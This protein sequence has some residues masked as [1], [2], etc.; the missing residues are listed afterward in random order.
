M[1]VLENHASWTLSDFFHFFEPPK[2]EPLTLDPRL[3]EAL[4][5]V[6]SVLENRIGEGGEPIYGINTGFGDLC[7]EEISRSELGQLQL[8][9]IRSHAC[10][11]GEEIPSR[12]SRLMLALK[13]I[14]FRTGHSAVSVELMDALI[15]LYNS[16]AA[17]VV[18]RK[19]SLGASGDLVPLA[20]LCL[21]LIG[22]GELWWNGRRMPAS[23]YWAA[24]GLSPVGLKAKEGLALLNGTQYMLAWGLDT[25]RRFRQ[26]MDHAMA[27][28]ALSS[29]A[30]MS[31][32][33]H[34]DPG[35]H[36][37]RA[38]YGQVHTAA[39]LRKWLE[40]SELA[41]LPRTQV[42]DPYSVRCQPQVLGASFDALRYVEGV[43]ETEL[44]AVTDN[45]L[46]FADRGKV[47]S[48]G[49]F[50]GQPLALS[51]DFLKIA[52]AEVANLAERLL[53][54]IIGGERG[55]PPYLTRNPGLESGFMIPQYS[56][57]ALVSENKQLAT[58]AS[59]DSIVSSNGQEDH[60]S[61]GASAALQAAAIADNL[62]SVLGILLM[63]GAQALEYRRPLRTSP[64]LEMY[65]SGFRRV[66]DF[67]QSDRVFKP[68]Q[69]A[70]AQFVRTHLVATP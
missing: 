9:L 13:I 31:R 65:V 21:P 51:L 29:D 38:H 26:C 47:I 7:R 22:E 40:G 63:A 57:A 1:P 8:N 27:I 28:F 14:S 59:V 6:R 18:Y 61:M 68:D 52:M 10:G 35:I 44:N 4:Q 37:V 41:A 25:A 24:R 69:D 54:K 62:E 49:N 66:V 5:R 34:L 55:L 58:P 30:W 2:P 33:D 45:P 64:A 50:H 46:L 20:H 32:T 11:V 23:E 60:V 17:P 12:I 53:F 67:R 42:Q 56:A 48:G 43:L 16:G 36:E 39:S 3:R 19:G 15:D 70:A